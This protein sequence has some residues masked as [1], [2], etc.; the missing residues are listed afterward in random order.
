[1]DAINFA[2][3]YSSV[4]GTNIAIT[5]KILLTGTINTSSQSIFLITIFLFF[6]KNSNAILISTNQ[7]NFDKIV[8]MIA[9]SVFPII[10]IISMPHKI[11]MKQTITSDSIPIRHKNRTSTSLILIEPSYNQVKTQKK[12]TEKITIFSH[13]GNSKKYVVTFEMI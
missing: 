3:T 8:Y 1:M 5:I 4:N 13:D 6:F 7:T 10:C 9:T 2:H 11:P 12:D